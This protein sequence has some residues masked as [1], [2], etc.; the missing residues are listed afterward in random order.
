MAKQAAL[1][2]EKKRLKLYL[3]LKNKRENL[4]YLF[5]KEKNLEKKLEYSYLIQKLN[6]NSSKTRQ[7]NR[8]WFS[9]RA[10]GVYS[11]F[12]LQKMALRMHAYQNI[13]PGLIKSSW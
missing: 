10:R 12:G 3:A 9:G 8:C 1:E 4:L 2:R 11:F 5:K 13:L 7:K 6:R